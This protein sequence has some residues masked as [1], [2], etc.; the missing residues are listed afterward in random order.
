MESITKNFRKIAIGLGIFFGIILFL[1]I[2][3]QFFGFYD[4]LYRIH[5]Y[6]AIGLTSLVGL[7]IIY[8]VVRLGY[9]WFNSSKALVLSEN[10][11]QEE[12]DQYLENTIS[13]LKKNRFLKDFDFENEN[14][15]NADKVSLAF[16]ELD[17][18]TFPY[19]RTTAN[20]IFLSTA[21]S[22]N[23]A[24]DSILIL[25]S[26]LRMI[27]R[28]ANVYQTRPSIKS[29]FKLYLQVGSVMFMAR[30]IED[31]DLIEDQMEVIIAS[32]LGD[33]LLSTIPGFKSVSNLVISSIMEG[34]VNALLSLRVGAISQA[35]LGMESPQTKTFIKKYASLL[36]LKYLGSIVRDNSKVVVK[37]MAKSAKNATTGVARKIFDFR[38]D[39]DE[40]Y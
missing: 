31:S 1:F 36:S 19:I 34:S 21:I 15:T 9:L 4:L 40:I 28:L 24:L 25:V 12:Y 30:S 10:P 32:I 11:S 35:Y 17:N 33:S 39:K 6:L 20:E 14:L 2:V 13:L 8:I 18:Q 38:K 27:W 16:K 26:L 23:G 22:Q 5:P 29:I 37:T 3:N 7:I